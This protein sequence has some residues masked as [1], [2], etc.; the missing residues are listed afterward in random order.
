MDSKL[1]MRR[2]N[3]LKSD[4]KGTYVHGKGY[5]MVTDYE[6]IVTEYKA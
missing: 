6:V 3:V 1:K 5:P 2:V 4:L